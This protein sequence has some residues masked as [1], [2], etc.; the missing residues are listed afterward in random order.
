MCGVD[1]DGMELDTLDGAPFLAVNG[2][3]TLSRTV[4]NL[5]REVDTLG[6]AGI[7]CFR[8]SPHAVDMVAVAACFRAVLDGCEDAAAAEARLAQIADFAP[9]SNGFL[10]GQEG[11]RRIA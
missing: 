3:Q 4:C 1:S 5:V 2:T 11:A 9:F 6:R 7:R 8:L 10:H